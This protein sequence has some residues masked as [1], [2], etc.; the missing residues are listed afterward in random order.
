MTQAH[1]VVAAAL[2]QALV[3]LTD[4]SLQGKQAHWNIEGP[5][6]RSLHLHLDEIID[7]VRLAADDVAERM[8]AIEVA[9]DARA[10]TVAATSLVDPMDPGFLPTDKTARQY[11]ERLLAVSE[12][13]KA[14]LDPV[15]EHDHLS[16]DLLIGIATGLEKQAWMLRAATK[17]LNPLTHCPKNNR[18]S[19]TDSWSAIDHET[20]L[21]PR[22]NTG[23]TVFA[24]PPSLVAGNE[25][26]L[27]TPLTLSFICVSLDAR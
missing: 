14:T 2:Q 19:S 27:I 1:P 21:F 11:E 23:Y 12:R 9:P 24:P 8:A 22:R 26:L 20:T 10:A 13:I 17:D 25:M 4:L 7:E 15:D 6:F 18:T 16:N 5:G 3:D